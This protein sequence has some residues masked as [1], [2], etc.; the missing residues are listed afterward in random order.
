MTEAAQQRPIKLTCNNLWKVYGARAD[1][2]DRGDG[3][4]AGD[5]VAACEKL[6]AGGHIPAV[7]DA[8][9]VVHT[10]EIFVI[11]GL[12]GSGK[13][14]LVRCLSRLIEPS[15]GQ[16]LLDG[17][18]LLAA[19]P[20]RLIALRRRE[21]GMVFQHFGLLPHL[22][23]LDNVAFP[24]RMQGRPIEERRSRAREMISLVGLEG[25]ER[26]FP[27]QLSGGQQQ[28]VGLARSLAVGPALWFL[29]EPFSALDPLIRRQMQD[30]FLR[31][32]RMLSK[33]II[34]ITHDMQ[35][36][37]RLAD[38]IA[39]MR[40]GEII[41]IGRPADIVR[42][43]ADDYVARFVEDIPLVRV[44]LAKDIMQPVNGGVT[45]ADAVEPTATVEDLLARL[46]GGSAG[47]RVVDDTGDA[48]GAIDAAAVLSIVDR[49]R[50]RRR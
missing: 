23:V 22:N 33:T 47:F 16:V 27:H 37:F 32:Q 17:E 43:P 40:Q 26:S 19:S 36:A 49:D 29:D 11:M 1:R 15:S 6:R 8:N 39:I 28:R 5:R 34:F 42:E 25:R 30:E 12:S 3:L 41:Q 48:L 38:R 21:M 50:Q 4:F 14:T 24:L 20:Q 35:E 13:S 2:L 18:D 10:G 9:F 45:R 46:A 44:M 31:L 7:I